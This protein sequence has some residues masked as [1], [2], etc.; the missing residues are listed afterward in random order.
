M[1]Y[2]G[3]VAELPKDP[4]TTE[5]NDTEK[6]KEEEEVDDVFPEKEAGDEQEKEGG[7]EKDTAT[8]SEISPNLIIPEVRVEDDVNS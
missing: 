4:A 8:K 7:T 6:V 1:N 5:A 2:E 3:W